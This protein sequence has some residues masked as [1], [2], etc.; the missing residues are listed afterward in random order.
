VACIGTRCVG[1]AAWAPL[2][3]PVGVCEPADGVDHGGDGAG[4][5]GEVDG[6]ELVAGLVVVLVEA[7]AGDGLGDDALLG[8]C[9]VVGATEELL[10]GMGI[11]DEV[12]AVFCELGAEVGA[13]EAGEPESAG[14]DGGVGAADH[15]ELEVGDDGVEGDGGMGEE[16]AVA[17]AAHLLGAEEGEDD[18]APGAR[19]AG[20]DVREGEDGGGAGG[21]VVG[22]VVDGVAGCVGGADAEVVQVGG[23]EDDFVG[24]AGSAQDAD[25]VP[26]LFAGCVFEAGDSLLGAGGQRVGERGFLHEGAVV[27][28]GFEAEGLELGGGEEGGDV[29]VACGGAAT[30]KLVVGEEVHIC[31]NFSFK[32]GRGRCRLGGGCV[33]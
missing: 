5:V 10:G 20:E 3:L 22:S 2:W 24:C 21:V 29:L 17:E 27:S 30:V 31:V 6:A 25:G 26:G 8:E 14:G 13:V 11:G 16:G 32:K 23:E 33:E 1:A 9:V 15:L 7:V 18:G 19:A 28:S 12:R 4:H